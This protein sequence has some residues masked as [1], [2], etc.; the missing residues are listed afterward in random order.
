M[1]T[2]EV[3]VG[4]STTVVFSKRIRMGGF[5]VLEV[6]GL[7]PL[8]VWV[9]VSCLPSLKALYTC[10]LWHWTLWSSCLRLSAERQ[11]F[12]SGASD[13]HIGW[14]QSTVEV[15]LKCLMWF[16]LQS[17]MTTWRSWTSSRF[18]AV[19]LFVAVCFN[20]LIHLGPA[21]RSAL[22]LSN[23]VFVLA[24]AEHKLYLESCGSWSVIQEVSTS[25]YKWEQ[26]AVVQELSTSLYKPT[27][28]T[29]EQGWS[30]IKSEFL[31][32]SF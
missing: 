26:V 21:A 25:L 31:I 22:Y 23:E 24:R 30:W 13:L 17:V 20:V 8:W 10:F 12:L 11:L 5:C 27:P 4:K 15:L 1:S 6:S 16:S 28:V 18:T 7:P 32:K 9:P 3:Q 29:Q 2:A 19:S 14:S